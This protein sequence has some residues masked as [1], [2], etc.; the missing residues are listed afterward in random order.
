MNGCHNRAEFRPFFVVQDGWFLDGV[1]RVPKMIK[2]PHTM[3]TTCQYR[4]DD[5]VGRKDKKCENCK[6]K[7][8][9]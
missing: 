4:L 3:T 8:R 1:T 6:E 9:A 7:D 5:M 2:V